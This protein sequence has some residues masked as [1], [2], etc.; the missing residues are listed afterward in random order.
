MEKISFH[1]LGE[2]WTA[3]Y[4]E[5]DKYVRRHGNDSEAVAIL[6][7]REIHFN[8]EDFSPIVVRHEIW[9]GF[10]HFQVISSAYLTTDQ[11]EEVY[12]EMFGRWGEDMLKISR[13]LYNYFKK[14][15]RNVRTGKKVRSRKT[16][17]RLTPLRVTKRNRK[18][19][20]VR[21]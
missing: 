11:T 10:C 5:D 15:P 20:R 19:S 1:I 4:H 12:A 21:R 6:E 14:G 13:K 8:A 2:K 3:F 18:S 7:K 17:T 9:H 16:T